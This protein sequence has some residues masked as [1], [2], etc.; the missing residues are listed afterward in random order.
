MFIWMPPREDP[1]TP[2]EAPNE[3]PTRP[4]SVPDEGNA[5][6]LLAVLLQIV[7]PGAIGAALTGLMAFVMFYPE[8]T[9]PSPAPIF[10]LGG[11]VVGF[12]TWLFGLIADRASR[13]RLAMTVLCAALGFFVAFLLYLF[14][15]W[16]PHRPGVAAAALSLV[17]AVAFALP[18]AGA[19]AGYYWLWGKLRRN[20]EAAENEGQQERR[21]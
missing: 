21:D 13:E 2:R 10:I 5:L 16:V 17:V 15:R 7:I 9:P 4:R 3:E 18:I 6:M 20:I 1:N 11:P 12:L 19:M 8:G 14:L